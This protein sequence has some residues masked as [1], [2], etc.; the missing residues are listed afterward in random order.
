MKRVS[1]LEF[2]Q[3]YFRKT[4]DSRTAGAA[5]P[6]SVV[7]RKKHLDPGEGVGPGGSCAE[8]AGAPQTE[9]Q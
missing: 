6:V 1:R 4:T 3:R 5:D 7:M 2:L 9:E 8:R